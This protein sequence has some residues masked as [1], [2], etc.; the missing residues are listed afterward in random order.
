[1]SNTL[2]RLV[3]TGRKVL[4]LG[5]SSGKLS[6]AASSMPEGTESN[7]DQEAQRSQKSLFRAK[8]GTRPAKRRSVFGSRGSSRG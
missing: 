5:S 8:P 7:P 1:M 4:G 3:E 6:S 2:T